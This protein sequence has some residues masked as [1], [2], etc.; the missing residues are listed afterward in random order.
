MSL[1]VLYTDQN[2][3]LGS[4]VLIPQ[5]AIMMW[6]G[7]TAPIGWALCDGR[8]VNGIQTPDLRGRFVRMY[9]EDNNQTGWG[10][11]YK[12]IKN[13]GHADNSILGV[14]RSD[15]RSVIFSNTKIGDTGGTDIQGLDLNEMPGHSHSGSVNVSG[16]TNT[17]GNHSHT[18]YMMGDSFYHDNWIPARGSN[19]PHG[20]YGKTSG[21]GDHS[22]SVSASGSFTTDS[23]G[24]GW[25]H[26]N[27]PPYYVLA[28]I[29]KV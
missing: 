5:G 19:S 21:A 27:S 16:S 18:F 11:Y 10:G 9:S 26:N 22:H 29:M 12:N 17:S 15:K 8:T 13:S 1:N 20:E 23:K 24:S 2:G 3:N 7:S 4:T 14:S 25:G 6:S 28:F